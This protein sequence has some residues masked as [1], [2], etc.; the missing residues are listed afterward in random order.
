MAEHF[1]L[2]VYIFLLSISFLLVTLISNFKINW[3]EIIPTFKILLI[4]AQKNLL[5][6]T[7]DQEYLIFVS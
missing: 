6:S 3:I 4:L 1:S 5:K 2:Q 7:C